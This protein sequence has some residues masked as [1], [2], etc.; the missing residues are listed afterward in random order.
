ME[1]KIE[2]WPMKA[3]EKLVRG[4]AIDLAE[5]ESRANQQILKVCQQP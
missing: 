1:V 4:A 3:V 2:T 5:L